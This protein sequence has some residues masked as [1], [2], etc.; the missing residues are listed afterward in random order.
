MLKVK[1]ILCL[2]FVASCSHV[3]VK[4]VNNLEVY[5]LIKKEIK[6]KNAVH[7]KECN[8]MKAFYRNLFPW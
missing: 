8:C 2:L 1:I 5:S 7:L 6:E 4:N 3:P